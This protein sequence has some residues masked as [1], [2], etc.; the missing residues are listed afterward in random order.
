MGRNRRFNRD[1]NAKLIR[2]VIRH[3]GRHI[4]PPNYVFHE[5]KSMFVHVDIHHVA[6][7]E[8]RP[9]HTLVTSGMSERRMRVPR[10]QRNEAF[11]E[12]FLRLP[13]EWPI[14][15][16][17][18]MKAPRWS[19]PLRMLTD[20][21]RYPHEASTWIGA[22]HLI[23]HYEPPEPYADSTAQCAALVM[24][25]NTE[26]AGFSRMKLGRHD[27]HF[28]QVFPLYEEEVR[29]AFQHSLNA[30]L[31]RFAINGVTEIIDPERINVCAGGSRVE[32]L[33]H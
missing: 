13:P 26:S 16:P 30:V 19:W 3:I 17:K 25:P 27:V 20:L 28:Y 21:A 8:Q 2:A 6:P 18:A 22:G 31:E 32:K 12:L 15:D 23:Q 11:A 24:H 10:E 7:T 4:G 14:F 29:F 5:E 9:F 33:V 1:G